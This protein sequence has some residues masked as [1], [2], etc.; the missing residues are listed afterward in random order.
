M[1]SGDLLPLAK[2]KKEIV[3]AIRELKDGGTEYEP[4]Q[5]NEKL[6]RMVAARSLNWG[7]R[8]KEADIITTNGCM[9]ALALCLMA[10]AKPGDT[11]ALK[12][13]VIPASY[14]WRLVLV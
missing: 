13:L 10:V 7:G 6:R 11:L 5:G 1:P 9:N 12:A 14:S 3:A 8:L 2:L 4:L